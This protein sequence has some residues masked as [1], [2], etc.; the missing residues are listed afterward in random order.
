MMHGRKNIKKTSDIHIGW[1]VYVNEPDG[2]L[3]APCAQA[4]CLQPLVWEE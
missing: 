2:N 1:M 3:T 4:T